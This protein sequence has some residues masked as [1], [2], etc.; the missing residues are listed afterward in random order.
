MS[1]VQYLPVLFILDLLLPLFL[2]AT[3]DVNFNHI[4]CAE[5]I[6]IQIYTLPM[7]P[8]KTDA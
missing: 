3:T 4:S 7:F 5:G 6:S 1:H 8:V 2:R